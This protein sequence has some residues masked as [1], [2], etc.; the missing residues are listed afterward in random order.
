MIIP[1]RKAYKKVN[2]QS[3]FFKSTLDLKLFLMHCL[4]TSLHTPVP[5]KH[6]RHADVHKDVCSIALNGSR[7]WVQT[8]E[9]AANTTSD[10]IAVISLSEGKSETSNP[11]QHYFQLTSSNTNLLSMYF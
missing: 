3:L 5:T 1:T 4:G 2:M 11:G 8:L 6:G 10:F 9:P 7:V